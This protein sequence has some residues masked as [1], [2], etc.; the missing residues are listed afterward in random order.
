MKW[1]RSGV[2]VSQVSIDVVVSKSG[3]HHIDPRP[4]SAISTITSVSRD[5][6][7]CYR[8]GHRNHTAPENTE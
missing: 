7:N 5:E 1:S 2:V 3:T 8:D 6:N 4:L